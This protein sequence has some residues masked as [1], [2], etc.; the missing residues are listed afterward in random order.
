M[1]LVLLFDDFSS[2]VPPRRKIPDEDS[3]VT[4]KMCS[5]SGVKIE[6]WS[7]TPTTTTSSSSGGSRSSSNEVLPGAVL[8]MIANETKIRIAFKRNMSDSSLMSTRIA[9]HLGDVIWILTQS[10]LRA[11][12]RLVQTLMDAA[13]KSAQRMRE[14]REKESEGST[15]SLE[16]LASVSGDTPFS[17]KLSSHSQEQQRQA[18]KNRK[19]SSKKRSQ[20][21]TANE[22]LVKQ[23]ISDY[24]DGKLNIPRYE[25]IQNSFHLR[26]GKIDLQLCND[27][28]KE[29]G[30]SKVQGS[31]LIQL[32]ELVVDV[33]LDQPAGVGRAQW[34]MANDL[35]TKNRE[36]VLIIESMSLEIGWEV[37]CRFRGVGLSLEKWVGLTRVVELE[38]WEGGGAGLH[39]T[40]QC[41][42]SNK[43]VGLITI[44]TTQT[45]M[46]VLWAHA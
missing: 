36:Y 15:S 44:F 43:G 11:L 16:S 4:F 20:A 7:T 35:T 21:P 37:T 3:V 24:R 18:K 9:V 38:K 12:S 29:D 32:T 46:F 41:C 31:M 8:R 19:G 40:S 17:H 5:W 10:Q 25:V 26:S 22:K 30:S 45:A 28:V 23:R 6:G 13:V 42:S 33:Y 34:N 14:E 1:S 2:T 39:S 27:V